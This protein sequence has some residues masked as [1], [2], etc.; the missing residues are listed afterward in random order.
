MTGHPEPSTDNT[1]LELTGQSLEESLTRLS[2]EQIRF[3][4]AR[5]NAK[6]DKEAARLIGLSPNTVYSWSGEAKAIIHRAQRTYLQNAILAAQAVLQRHV[7]EAALVKIQALQGHPEG[8]DKLKQDAATEILDR[9]L[10]KPRQSV[11]VI[12]H[13]EGNGEGDVVPKTYVTISPD[14]WDEKS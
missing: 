1:N 8:Q 2:T 3:I 5:L 4:S 12:G 6:N 11:D 13:G 7:L 10:G 9:M 14:M